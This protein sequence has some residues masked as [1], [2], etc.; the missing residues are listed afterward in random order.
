MNEFLL[1]D[2]ASL[3]FE[4][5]SGCELHRDP[6][7]GKVKFLPLGRWRGTLQQEDIPLPY[8][9]LSDHL[10][11]VGVLLKS[12]F[13]KTR[14]A[15][16]DELIEKFGKII[17]PWKSGK[18]MPL[19]QRPYS[20]NTYALPKIWFRCHA[21]E[22]RAG[23][24]DKINSSIKSWLYSDLLEKPEELAMFKPKRVG[25]L[26]V[27][28]VKFKAMAILI[29]SF[30][31]S[32]VDPKYINNAYHHALYRY[33]VIGDNSLVEPDKSPYYSPEFFNAIKLVLQEGLLNV[34]TMSTKQWYRVLMENHFT[35]ELD[36]T[37]NR[38]RKALKCE[39]IHQAVDW[40]RSWQLSQL[41]GLDSSQSTFLLSKP[42]P[43]ST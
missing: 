28:H 24:F 25:G 23:D 10:D 12:S 8:I 1:V 3:L 32:A 9:K 13:I 27:Q 34:V 29:R 16:C 31:E 6:A 4:M 36:A 41:K 26:G 14:K 33:H 30:I 19:S 42:I 11:M 20:I 38:I 43:N 18:F 5:A 7:S 17:G 22:L 40:D 39:I 2:R 15:N 37:G 21:L 35:M